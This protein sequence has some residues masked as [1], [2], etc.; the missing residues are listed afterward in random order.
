MHFRQDRIVADDH[1]LFRREPIGDHRRCR[2]DAGD[3]PR[4]DPFDNGG[5]RRPEC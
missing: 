2:S 5:E 1:R 4:P 3:Q